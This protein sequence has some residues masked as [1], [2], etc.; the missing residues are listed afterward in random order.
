MSEGAREEQQKE[1][2]EGAAEESPESRRVAEWRAA[3]LTVR[4]IRVRGQLWVVIDFLKAASRVLQGV[5]KSLS[6]SVEQAG[7]AGLEQDVWRDARQLTAAV[8][9]GCVEPAAD[10]LLTVVLYQLPDEES[11]LASLGA[12]GR[13]KVA[14]ARPAPGRPKLPH[15]A[16]PLGANGGRDVQDVVGAARQELQAAA[17]DLKSIRYRMLGVHASIPPTSQETSKGDLDGKMDVETE[18][19]VPDPDGRDHGRATRGSRRSL[20][21]QCGAARRF[22]SGDLP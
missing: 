1:E 22:I 21:S 9:T 11:F 3:A 4:A 16:A 5:V 13:K 19:R 6:P 18:L 12:E 2:R 17:E 8:L 15:F 7:E 20:F 14:S 10:D